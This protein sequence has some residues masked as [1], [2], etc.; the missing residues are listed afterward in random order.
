MSMKV[1]SRRQLMMEMRRPYDAEIEYL[2]SSGTQYINLPFGFDKTDE[3]YFSFSVKNTQTRDK[4]MNS[5]TSWNNNN[6]RFG[7]GVHNSLYTFAYGNQATGYTNLLPSR[8]NDGAIHNWVYKNYICSVTDLNISRDCSSYT[9]GATTVNLRLF[10]GYDS[11]TSGKIAYYKHIKNGVVV[12]EL[13]PVR[14]G[15]TG[16]LYDKVSG[17]LFGNAGTGN[18]ILGPDKH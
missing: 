6:N 13:I 18:F 5:P 14:I 17:K 7:M 3:I 11:N 2:E 4:Y 12:V 1:Y 8:A 15:T 9:F 16:Y 10:F